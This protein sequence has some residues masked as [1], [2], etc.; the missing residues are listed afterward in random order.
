MKMT[1]EYRSGD[2]FAQS[3]LAALGHGVNCR[4]V[5]GSGIAPLFKNCYPEMF[6]AYHQLCVRNVL[7]PGLVYPW[8]DEPTG[9]WIFNM[10]TQD[11]PGRDARLEAVKTTV[12]KVLA[13]CENNG[14]E[15][16][17]L[18]R[19]GCGIGGLQWK[20]VLKE[21]ERL[22]QDSSVRVVLV[23]LPERPES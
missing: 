19:I 6:K 7:E 22:A 9:L 10:A 11:E 21:I 3:D 8:K 2:L 14:I 15:S 5:M 17:G 20:T 13:F 1:V 23:S 4:G 12:G 18:P 16:L